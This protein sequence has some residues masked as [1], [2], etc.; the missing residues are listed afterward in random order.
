M[1]TIGAAKFKAECLSLLDHIPPTGLVI[2]KH[3]RPV[4]RIL[5]YDDGSCA[6]LIGCMKDHIKVYGDIFS[7]GI[8]WDAT[9][10][11]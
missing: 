10:K 2:T 11:H 9:R 8:K 7:T 5:P 4:A 1:K 3:G 6:H